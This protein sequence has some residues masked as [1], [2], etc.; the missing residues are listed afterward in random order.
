MQEVPEQER[1]RAL[2]R[3][4]RSLAARAHTEKELVDKLARAGYSDEAI[5]SVMETLT[6]YKLI[7]DAAFA[8]SWVN[9]RAKRGMGPYRLM[10]ELR[11]KGVSREDSDSAIAALDEEESLTAAADFARRRLKD[12]SPDDRRRTM[13]ALLRRGYGYET[14]RSA[15]ERA[16][17]ESLEEE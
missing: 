17:G 15:L 8:E 9:A 2:D 6:R 11:R 3:A 4:F 7:D 5:A 13:Q 12:G 1:Q 16:L 14:A 10:Q